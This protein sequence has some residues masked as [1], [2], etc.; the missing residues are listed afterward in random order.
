MQSLAVVVAGRFETRTGGSL[1]NRRMVECLVRRGWIVALHELDDSFPFPTTEALS[2][3]A[4]VLNQIESGSLV[5]VDGLAFG[6]MP[7]VVRNASS[8]LRLAA[9]VH[10]PLA[11]T[12]GLSPED[13]ACLQALEQRALSSAVLVVVTGQSTQRLMGDVGLS[14]ARVVVVEPGTDPAPLARGSGSADVQILT[15]ATLNPGKGYE[16]LLEAFARLVHLNWHLTCAGSLTRHRVTTNRVEACRSRLGLERRVSLLGELDDAA[17]DVCYDGAD[18]FVLASLRETYGMAVAEA[19]ARGLPVVGTATGAIP[20]LV[21]LDAGIVVPPGDRDALT[22]ALS[23]MIEDAD[24]RA[25]S[26]DGARRARE[27]L[28][29]WD[30]AADRLASALQAIDAHG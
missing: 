22:E 5:L 2:H 28:L 27:T 30:R 4:Q 24:L 10:L 1:Y 26:A 7:E 15:V 18:L 19:L 16:I 20:R 25:R 17:L 13:T 21:G 12:V 11:A 29:D 6:A 3:A 14:H 8:R 23:R 9:L